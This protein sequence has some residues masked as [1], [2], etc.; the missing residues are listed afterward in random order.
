MG[1]V[2]SLQHHLHLDLIPDGDIIDSD[3]GHVRL[4]LARLLHGIAMDS[5]YDESSLLVEAYGCSI[6]V[7][8]YQPEPAAPDDF[9]VGSFDPTGYQPDLVFVVD[10][11]RSREMIGAMCPASCNNRC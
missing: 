8:G 2:D 9:A 7:S 5:S 6:I 4:E 3:F 10:G 11:N 1:A